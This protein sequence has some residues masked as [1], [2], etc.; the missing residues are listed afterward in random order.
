MKMKERIEE[1]RLNLKLKKYDIKKKSN[2]S[3]ER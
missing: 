3:S 1:I 2:K